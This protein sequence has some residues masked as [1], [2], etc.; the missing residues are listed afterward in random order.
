MTLKERIADHRNKAACRSCHAKIDPWG[1]AF[2]PQHEALVISERRQRRLAVLTINAKDQF[3]P[4]RFI[5]VN[6]KASGFG[7]F[8]MFKSPDAGPMA[9][10]SLGDGGLAVTT[11]RVSGEAV[12]Y[13]NEVIV[14]NSQG[15]EQYR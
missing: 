7:L 2:W 9:V 15:R 5:K 14:Y 3:T 4:S 13:L 10:A 11:A 1:I 12:T 8:A 6:A